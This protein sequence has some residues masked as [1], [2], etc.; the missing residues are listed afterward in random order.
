MNQIKQ[1]IKEVIDKSGH[2][3]VIIKITDSQVS[4]VEV[5]IKD[6]PTEELKQ[7]VLELVD[8]SIVCI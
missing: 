5:R 3:E 8:E 6:K 1:K 4:L 7:E 2:G